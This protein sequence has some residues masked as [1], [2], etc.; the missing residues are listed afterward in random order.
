MR[1]KLYNLTVLFMFW[2]R[3]F[4]CS[5]GDRCR[6]KGYGKVMPSGGSTRSQC[7]TSRIYKAS[8][9]YVSDGLFG[10]YTASRPLAHGS[11]RSLIDRRCRSV[12][13]QAFSPNKPHTLYRHA[14][15]SVHW[16]GVPGNKERIA[17]LITHRKRSQADTLPRQVH[18][19]QHPC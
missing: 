15:R 13:A 2:W 5:H 19:S 7:P 6:R 3:Y 9:N 17:R 8:T 1:S 4:V 11:H 12:T 16:P 10:A 14:S 18:C